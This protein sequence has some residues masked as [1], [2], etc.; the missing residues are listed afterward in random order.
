MAQIDKLPK[1]ITAKFLS[2]HGACSDDVLLFEQTFPKGATVTL[3]NVRKAEKAGLAIHWLVA[4]TVKYDDC[5][6]CSHARPD[7]ID[8]SKVA[9]NLLK[10]F[11]AK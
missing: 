11:I 2:G 3:A 6:L 7:D 5:L 4:K 1:R 8:V 10:P 9:F